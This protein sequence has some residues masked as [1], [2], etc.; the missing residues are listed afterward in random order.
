MQTSFE[1]ITE[2]AYRPADQ[3]IS[4]GMADE[5]YAELW[6]P[7]EGPAPAALIV[8]IHGGCWLA[9]YDISHIRPMAAEL[10]SHGLFVLALEYRRVGQ[11]S[12]GWP[13]T[14]SDISDALDFIPSLDHRRLDLSN[15]I[16][17]GHSA[18]GH[19]ALWAAG[20]SLLKKPQSL[21]RN[22]PFMPRG[23]IGLAAI[24]DL[25]AY[26]EGQNSCQKVTSRLMGGLP[27]EKPGRYAQ[28]SP[29]LLGTAIPTVLLHG[30]QDPVVPISQAQALRQARLVTIEGAGHF[31]LI[32][33]GREAFPHLLTSIQELLAP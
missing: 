15:V 25:A 13:A 18:G 9:E 4:Y 17:V 2:L 12:D 5:Q 31:D 33:P 1:E 23:V 6:L 30:E 22:K 20:R 10:A 29:S 21:Y 14:F 7:A 32:H 27:S 3:H 11:E 28:A 19:L 26:A 8:L 16:L 24:T